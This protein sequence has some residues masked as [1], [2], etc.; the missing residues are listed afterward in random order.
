MKL[1]NFLKLYPYKNEYVT[2]LAV[3]IVFI[4][5]CF[6]QDNPKIKNLQLIINK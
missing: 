2:V 5:L 1:P 6:W 3:M 4:I